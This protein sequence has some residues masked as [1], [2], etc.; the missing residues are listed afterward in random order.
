[1]LKNECEWIWGLRNLRTELSRWRFERHAP[2]AHPRSTGVVAEAASRARV[3]GQLGAD[4]FLFCQDRRL[5]SFEEEVFVWFMSVIPKTHSFLVVCFT[6][7]R[8]D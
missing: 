3:R 7:Y 5:R 6:N 4:M 8:V 2:L 1:M